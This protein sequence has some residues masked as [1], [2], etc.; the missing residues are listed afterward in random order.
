VALSEL[1]IAAGMAGRSVTLCFEGFPAPV[2]CQLYKYCIRYAGPE[3]V[4]NIYTQA[5]VRKLAKE[6]DQ[7]RLVL[8]HTARLCNLVS[9]TIQT[10]GLVLED[11][12]AKPAQF[13]CVGSRDAEDD[14]GATLVLRGD[15][16]EQAAV[17]QWLLTAGGDSPD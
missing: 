1:A 11:G 8:V 12:A 15:G 10:S 14:P 5:D 7:V 13:H 4:R 3:T 9:W 6:I 16:A 2:L 17:A